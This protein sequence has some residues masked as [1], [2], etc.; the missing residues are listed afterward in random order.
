M[1]WYAAINMRSDPEMCHLIVHDTRSAFSCAWHVLKLSK[2]VLTRRNASRYASLARI[3][4]G[5]AIIEV[6]GSVALTAND[7]ICALPVK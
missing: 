2:M 1:R 4:I 5:Y 7:I 6:R 3:M